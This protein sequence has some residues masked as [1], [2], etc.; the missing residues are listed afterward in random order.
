LRGDIVDSADAAASVPATKGPVYVHVADTLREEI[1][2]GI[3]P[4]GQRL[5]SEA[6][7]SERFGVARTSTREAL[8]VLLAQGLVR[9]QRGSLGGSVVTAVSQEEAMRILET[10]LRSMAIAEAC[11]E[12]EMDEFRELLDV[13]STWLA[14]SRRT[15]EHVHKL[16]DLITDVPAGQPPTA[17]DIQTNLRFHYQILEATGNRLLHLFGQPV[18]VMIY[19]FFRQQ[20]HQPRYYQVVIEDHRKIAKAIEQRNP[21]AARVAMIEHLAH[22]RYPD[23]E[24]PAR[25]AFA[26][27][28]F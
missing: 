25:S 14:A 17:A 26:G 10:S 20:E 24:G 6:A 3:H 23:D 18:S 11:T 12:Q 1:L 2:L 13:T 21:D 19:S 8:R 7:L 4:A 9:T 22:L 15:P 16:Y 28:S 27:L 5:P